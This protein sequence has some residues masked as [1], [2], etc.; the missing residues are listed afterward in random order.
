M[1]NKTSIVV[2]HLLL[3]GQTDISWIK[4]YYTLEALNYGYY[5]S[6]FSI[7]FFFLIKIEAKLLLSEP[8]KVSYF[9][10]IAL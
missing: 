6:C 4:N 1:A 9:G 3:K 8:I 5:K 7:N 10:L 2:I